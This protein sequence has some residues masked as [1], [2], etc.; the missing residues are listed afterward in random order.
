MATHFDN[1]VQMSGAALGAYTN[2]LRA[3][4]PP[5]L[6]SI[7]FPESLSSFLRNTILAIALLDV[8][9]FMSTFFT[10]SSRYLG[11]TT[12]MVSV[13]SLLH[14]SYIAILLGNHLVQGIPPHQI[15]PNGVIDQLQQLS[16]RAT[17]VFAHG[18]A[19]GSTALMALLMHVVWAYYA[20]VNDCVLNLDARLEHAYNITHNGHHGHTP[21]YSAIDNVNHLICGAYGPV[22]FVS[23]LSGIL[24]WLNL[25]LAIALY[26]K[27]TELS[28]GGSLTM[29]AEYEE[30]HSDLNLREEEVNG[31]RVMQV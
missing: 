20:R 1:N 12:M 10:W 21:S 9:L 16:A 22:G 3:A 15:E 19:F 29:Q 4:M 13:F 18:T 27:R 8:L 31:M 24:Y 11:T 26:V 2:N 17:S 7:F 5:P 28:G 25:S 6:R 30:I 14:I 23:F